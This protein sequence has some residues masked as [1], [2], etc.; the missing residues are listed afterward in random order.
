MKA[1]RSSVIG[2]VLGLAI[3]ACSGD[4][5]PQPDGGD[6]CT[7]LTYD[8]CNTE[9][10]CMSHAC[11]EFMTEGFQVCTVAC[12]VSLPCPADSSGHPA[13]CN[14]NSVCEP[15]VANACHIN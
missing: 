12:N 4:P 10:D 11:Q 14:A 5:P 6:K 3:A 9:H 8:L 7:G 2:M 1:M 15:A 13:T